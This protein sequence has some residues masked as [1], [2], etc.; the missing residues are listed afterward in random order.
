MKLVLS[1]YVH[2]DTSET[3]NG[4]CDYI[5]SFVSHEVE[6]VSCTASF[7]ASHKQTIPLQ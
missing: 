5:L 1:Y 6:V 7:Y 3:A 2:D 4:Q